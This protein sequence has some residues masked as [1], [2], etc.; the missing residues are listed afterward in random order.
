MNE[1]YIDIDILEDYVFK[2]VFGRTTSKGLLEHF[3]ARV[4]N[5][6]VEV[7]QTLNTEIVR[8]IFDGKNVSLDVVIK[9]ENDTIIT[10]EVQ[11]DRIEEM[12]KRIKYYTDRL[13]STIL[14]KGE[15]YC[16]TQK[17]ISMA[18]L[19]HKFYK[20]D[21]HNYRHTFKLLN[22]KNHSIYDDDPLEIIIFDKIKKE[23][24]NVDD[25]VDRIFMYLF[26][27]FNNEELKNQTCLDDLIRDIEEVR[28]MISKSQEA[29]IAKIGIEKRQMDEQIRLKTAVKEAKTEGKIE[30]IKEGKIEG[31]E[32]EKENMA[33]KLKN[34]GFSLEE[35]SDIT[36]LSIKKLKNLNSNS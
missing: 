13:S 5:R 14:K 24:F 21:Q 36:N 15:N 30:G 28:N 29:E 33:L 1:R 2:L 27:Y 12:E 31:K 20:E 35:I 10:V 23:D 25:P 19:N 3:L 7:D 17:V 8:E 9:T 32:E 6:K 18:I 34:K 4:L 11:N 26:G 16:K 22:T